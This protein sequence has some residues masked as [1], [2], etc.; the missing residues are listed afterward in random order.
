MV[1]KYCELPRHR[2]TFS[3]PIVMEKFKNSDFS[4]FIYF[5]SFSYVALQ[6]LFYV[7]S[8][9]KTSFVVQRSY[10]TVPLYVSSSKVDIAYMTFLVCKTST[11]ALKPLE[12]NL[13]F[14]SSGK[15]F[16]TKHLVESSCWFG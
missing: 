4:N 14:I 9:S 2:C 3:E 8:S 12:P 5:F 6:F 1:G 13:N 16:I 11:S 7:K 15:I 10:K